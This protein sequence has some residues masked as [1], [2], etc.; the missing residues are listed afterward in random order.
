[1]PVLTKL[2]PAVAGAPDN[3]V[4]ESPP[5]KVSLDPKPLL[6]PDL[7]LCE[8]VNPVVTTSAV[9]LVPVQVRRVAACELAVRA[10]RAPKARSARGNNRDIFD[11]RSVVVIMVTKV[12]PG[13]VGY[14]GGFGLKSMID[15]L[16][17]VFG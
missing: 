1:M 7:P 11:L 17:N 12:Y 13:L 16:I 8:P 4:P 14:L 15:A 6:L 9:S 3:P 5:K 10:T 2:V